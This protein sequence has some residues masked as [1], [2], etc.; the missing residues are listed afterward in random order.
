MRPPKRKLR[1]RV[2]SGGRW[3]DLVEEQREGEPTSYVG[4]INGKETLRS[5]ERRATGVALVLLT[6]G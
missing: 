1:W 5:T 4:M 6:R 3:F 2:L